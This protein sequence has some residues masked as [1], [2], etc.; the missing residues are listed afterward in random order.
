MTATRD[1]ATAPA[2]GGLLRRFLAWLPA[3][4]FGSDVYARYT[5]AYTWQANQIGH[6]A[7]GFGAGFILLWL[8]AA[9]F[10]WAAWLLIGAYALKEAAD[11]GIA[12]VQA[13]GFFPADQ[14]ELLADMATDTFFVAAGVLIAN[15]SID[16]PYWAVAATAAL[17]LLLRF[18]L[19]DRVFLPAK[20]A[21]DRSDLPVYYRLPNFP[22]APTFRL[23]N[24]DRLV[25][26][27][28]GAPHNGQAPPRHVL[29]QGR[30]GT[31]EST[32]AAGL[33]A[34]LSNRR[35]R[36]RYTAAYALFEEPGPARD[37]SEAGQA[38][39]PA[40]IT[41]RRSRFNPETYGYTETEVL[42][43]DDVDADSAEF[44]GGTPAGIRARLERIKTT[45]RE[46]YDALKTGRVA[47][48]WVTGSL[49]YEANW[50]HWRDALAAFL[51]VAPDDATIPVIWLEAPMTSEGSGR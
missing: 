34:E 1:S 23:E 2:Q 8:G 50:Q 43:V 30:P 28:T 21:F 40:G 32:L 16:A 4:Y 26:L 15:V 13:Q 39:A 29:I 42:I 6:F 25:A 12:K 27:Y 20:E 14:G 17:G 33:G 36:V 18:V 51:D 37:E 46:A 49:D 9:P 48:V 22:K 31:G 45:R 35:R 44:G 5:A 10:G 24:R 41:R 47:T 11:F 3:E 19:G 38:V 7:I